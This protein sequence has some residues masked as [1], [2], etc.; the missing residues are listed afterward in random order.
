MRARGSI[1]GRADTAVLID[2]AHSLVLPAGAGDASPRAAAAASSNDQ[3]RLAS[4]LSTQAR[5]RT[6]SAAM[7]RFATCWRAEV[8]TCGNVVREI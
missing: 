1:L 8:Q 2:G 4:V 7:A 3:P 5:Q 6:F